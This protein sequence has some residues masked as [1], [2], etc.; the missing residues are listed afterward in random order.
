MAKKKL[1]LFS[2]KFKVGDKVKVLRKAKD[3]EGDW[4][5]TWN[6][7]MDTSVGKT[8]EVININ[9]GLHEYELRDGLVNFGYPEFILELAE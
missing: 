2:G 9:K 1:E 7:D 6:A 4:V 3:H 5:D 8:L